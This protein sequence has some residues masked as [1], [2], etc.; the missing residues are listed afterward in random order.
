M[1]DSASQLALY[2][3]ALL[4]CGSR[5]LVSL[6]ENREP[7]YLLDTAWNDGAVDGCLEEGQWYFAMRT[8]Q[9]DF[10]PAVQPTFGYRYAFDKPADWV[11]TAAVCEE[12]YFRVPLTRY[13]DQAGFWNAGLE[14]RYV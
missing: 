11:L 10:D 1:A 2:N 7:R 6:T 14:P 8:V 5:A 9:L 13:F 4:L 3:S 12:Q